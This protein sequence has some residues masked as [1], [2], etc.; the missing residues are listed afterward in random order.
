MICLPWLERV[1][2]SSIALCHQL[3][4]VFYRELQGLL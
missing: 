4:G 1:D 3:L 2:P